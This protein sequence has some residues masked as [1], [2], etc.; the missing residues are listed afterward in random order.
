MLN[1]GTL[2]QKLTRIRVVRPP[3]AVKYI[4]L[5]C[6]KGEW[7]VRL[8][9]LILEK[10]LSFY[11]SAALHFQTVTSFTISIHQLVL[12][13]SPRCVF[14]QSN[15]PRRRLGGAGGGLKLWGQMCVC[16]RVRTLRID[17]AV[18]AAVW[19]RSF[20]LLPTI[21][22]NFRPVIRKCY[23]TAKTVGSKAAACCE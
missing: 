14:M 20:G 13:P 19:L 12:L 9:D 21:P 16:V 10:A 8:I 18:L 4:L 7:I 1:Y 6:K 3:A 17:Q 22:S 5:V 11:V 2:G 23:R 15:S